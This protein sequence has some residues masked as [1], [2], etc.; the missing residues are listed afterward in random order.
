MEAKKIKLIAAK[1]RI[2]GE[3]LV[4]SHKFILGDAQCSVMMTVYNVLCIVY[5]CMWK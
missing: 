1:N 3:M 2:G 5:V 4:K